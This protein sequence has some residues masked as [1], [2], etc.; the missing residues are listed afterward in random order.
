VAASIAVR[1]IP[2]L[3]SIKVDTPPRW[4]EEPLPWRRPAWF[5]RAIRTAVGR[6]PPRTILL[7]PRRPTTRSVETQTSACHVL[8]PALVD[9]L[10]EHELA[11]RLKEATS[12]CGQ[13]IEIPSDDESSSPE[14][15]E[16]TQSLL[17]NPPIIVIQ[18]INL[19]E[20]DD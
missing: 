16:V 10:F 20:S 8:E 13:I 12:A 5:R 19:A 4:R 17:D 3:M 2:A 1:R 14:S 6:R 11:R 15:E 18:P 9:L 7:K